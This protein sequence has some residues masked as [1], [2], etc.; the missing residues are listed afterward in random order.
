MPWY[1]RLCSAADLLVGE[2]LVAWATPPAFAVVAAAATGLLMVA[3]WLPVGQ[4]R[5]PTSG[6]ARFATPLPS[7]CRGGDE[8]R[9][10]PMV[11]M[12]AALVKELAQ[13][14]PDDHRLRGETAHPEST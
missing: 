4:R 10:P 11:P 2:I 13:E 12:V 8:P 6:G 1:W 14:L 7:R 9:L 3:A 5:L